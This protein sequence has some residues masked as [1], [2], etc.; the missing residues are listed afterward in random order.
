[1]LDEIGT[2]GE[3]YDRMTQADTLVAALQKNIEAAEV[4]AASQEGPRV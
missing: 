2:L 1:M 4:V 3:R